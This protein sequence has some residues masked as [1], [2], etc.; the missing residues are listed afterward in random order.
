MLM[1]MKVV[2]KTTYL[3]ICLHSMKILFVRRA[4]MDLSGTSFIF[5]NARRWLAV[6]RQKN[7]YI[8]N[9]HKIKIY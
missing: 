6:V 5:R 3:F 1:L 7:Y 4:A 2:N 8:I 9:G